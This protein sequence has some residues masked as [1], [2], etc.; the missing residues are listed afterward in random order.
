MGHPF[1]SVPAIQRKRRRRLRKSLLT[2]FF[3]AIL[4]WFFPTAVAKTDLR[5]QLLAY[6]LKDLNGMLTAD[7]ASLGWLSPVELRGV[8]LKDKDGAVVAKA[9]R[10]VTDRSL[11][12][13]IRDHKTIGTIRVEKPTVDLVCDDKRTNVEALIE[14]YV[15]SNSPP[16]P[17]RVQLVV[18]IADGT[19]TIRN[20]D[21]SV[22]HSLPAIA[23]EVTVPA[24]K[25]E[26][27]AVVAKSAPGTPDELAVDMAFGDASRVK[28]DGS[29]VPLPVI[30]LVVRWFEP[31][32]TLDGTAVAH[33]S[34]KWDDASYSVDGTVSA[35]DFL[36]AGS[37]LGKDT[38]K[39]AK[40]DLPVKLS[41][42]GD[43]LVAE[44]LNLS[45]DAGTLSMSGTVDLAGNLDTLA[46]KPGL[47]VDADLNLT[48]LTAT[49]PRLFRIRKGTELSGGQLKAKLTSTA[50]PAGTVWT[51]ELSTSSI[52]GVRDGK[53]IVWEQPL[54]AGFAARLGPDRWPVFDKLELQSDFVGLAAKGSA[55]SF[56]AAANI[57]LGK[58]QAR[59][60]DF[61]DLEGIQLAG[62]AEVRL[63]SKPAPGGGFAID[64]TAALKQF[65]AVDDR[66]VGLREP[67]LALTLVAAAKKDG[68]KVRL[69]TGKVTL[70]AEGDS[71]E[72][73]LTEP[74]A[75]LA[76]LTSGR[77]ALTA[78]GD[79]THWQDRLRPFVV[80]PPD[81]ALRGTGRLTGTV[82]VSPKKI[83]F[84]G[85]VKVDRFALGPPAKPTWT[86]PTLAIAA[87]GDLDRAGDTVR[88][89]KLRVERDGLAVDAK[90]AV[91]ELSKSQ[92]VRVDGTIAY[93][94]KKLEP[95]LKEYLGK[96][97][98]VSGA[99]TRP[100]R[101]SG[102]LGG[103]ADSLAVLS[104]AAAV[105][106]QSLKAYGFDVGT[107]ELKAN[108]DAG[109]VTASTVAATFGG[110]QVRVTP[111]VRLSPGPAVLT[112][113]K[114]KVIDRAKLTP[115]ATADAIGYVLPAIANAA[116]A[117][118]MISFDLGDN[119]VPLADPTTAVLAGTLTLHAV[120]V[121]PGPVATELATLLGATN[122]TL[123]LANEQPVGVKVENG[124]VYHDSLTIDLR[125]YQVKTSGSVGFDGTLN[126][127]A[128]LPLPGRVIDEV[129]KKR[130]RLKEAL[131][132]HRVTVPIKGTL[133]KPQI[134]GKAF[135]A[136][137]QKVSVEAGEE[138][139]MKWLQGQ[140]P[141]KK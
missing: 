21:Q 42:R 130:P 29:K 36:A 67:N 41:V 38:L 40:L 23:G 83:G 79:L 50:G 82:A 81:L 71:A 58:M 9:D 88:F 78:T 137:V 28:L 141:T 57:D 115:A 63:N 132:K 105:D 43:T 75:D 64:A 6:A 33:L 80:L 113:A 86:E 110:G 10:I 77:F 35:A 97:A 45:C 65:A 135:Q 87:K 12:G 108:L 126:L 25:A 89:D 19:L 31:S 32:T 69:D 37:W 18:A 60:H 111:T 117:E 7:G 93:D 24:N 14:K 102:K 123:S 103:N 133:A 27:V 1:D 121:S 74:V 127:T 136:S 100:F 8:V 124:R 61:V 52:R 119:R 90:G 107:A 94:L 59:L 116:Q 20:P 2:F 68:G 101:L 84:D 46:D 11:F 114:G 73:G 85:A 56:A 13:L 66:G 98:V 134:D 72:V 112:F 104:A 120:K 5:N 106:W 62:L 128:E 30:G 131:A 53:P 129:L 47:A 22:S 91:Y 49:L 51:G 70:A 3:F 138:A 140:I 55:E 139:L 26:P 99:D 16:S 17:T 92:D 15:H 34:V 39:F 109:V 76:K 96:G 48:K 44:K 122:V 4:A 95:T 54:R 118:G 125:G